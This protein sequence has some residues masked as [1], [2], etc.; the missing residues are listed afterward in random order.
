MAIVKSEDMKR[1]KS[2]ER[3]RK[4]AKFLWEK[5]ETW[6][7]VWK[8]ISENMLPERGAFL[9]SPEEEP[10]KGERKD[11]K[12]IN[13]SAN[14]AVRVIAAGLQ[15]GLTSPSRPWFVLTLDDSDLMEYQPVKEWLHEVR[16]RMLSVL[17]RS[18]FY[19]STHGLYAELA[20]FGTGAM[21]IEEDFTS[22]IRCRP[23]TIGEFALGLD[24]AYRPNALYRRF[25]LT[26]EQMAGKFGE[27]NLSSAVKTALKSNKDQWFLVHHAI[28]P[29]QQVDPTKVDYRGMQFRSCY[30][31]D[32]TS[33]GEEKFLRQGGYRGIP[34]IGPRWEVTAVNIY[35]N[36]PGRSSLGDQKML[37]KLEEKKLKQLDKHTDPA[38]NA[39]AALKKKGGTIISGGVNYID[40]QQGQQSFVPAYQ[41]NPDIRPVAAEIDTVER[42]IRRFFFNDLFLAI[43]GSM[44]AKERTAME[45]AKAHEEKLIMIGPVIEQLQSEMHDPALDRIFNVMDDLN[46]FPPPPRELVGK[47]INVQYLGL[48]AQAQ[49]IVSVQSIERVANYVGAL[50]AVKPDVV[51]KFDFDQSVDEYAEAMGVPPDLVLSDERV[52]EIRQQRAQQQAQLTALATAEVAA[53]TGK[54]MS[55]TPVKGKSMADRMADQMGVR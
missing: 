38:M 33:E 13:G 42:R 54:T 44:D 10:N 5:Q 21:L 35:G 43:L 47:T 29:A 4:R 1:E 28:E 3:Y 24:A 55:E 18:N 14:D 49:K 32:K 34:F 12:I 27:N 31:E 17:A 48:L 19:G 30:W 37:Q 22:V 15:G 46:L 16:K 7:P 2:T 39:P 40:V 53:K 6:R 25:W 36:C 41:T 8:E 45:I 52:A 20:G 9:T 26:A 23:F 50:A 51:D 11:R